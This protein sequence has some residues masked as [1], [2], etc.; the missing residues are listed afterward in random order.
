MLGVLSVAAIPIAIPTTI[1]AQRMVLGN[2]SQQQDGSLPAEWQPMVFGSIE[3]HTDY[4]LVPEQGVPVLRAESNSAAS[5]LSYKVR[6]DPRV[7]PFIS[8]RWKVSTALKHTDVTS[9]AGDDYAA[10]LYVSFDYDVNKLPAREKTRINLF[11]L[12]KGFYPPLATLNYIWAGSARIGKM[13]PSPYTDRVRMV[14]VK[15][16]DSRT[17]QW[18]VEERNILEDYRAAFGEEPGDV[19][20][21]A[22]MTDTDNAGEK[23]TSYYGDIFVSKTPMLAKH[24]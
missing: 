18:H 10:R 12:I 20:S 5:G 14:V 6:F 11:Y 4:Q 15:N 2:F 9:K 23:T 22:V 19:V 17:Q 3:K 16:R 13:V 1:Q 21:V 8:W 24:P 7:Y